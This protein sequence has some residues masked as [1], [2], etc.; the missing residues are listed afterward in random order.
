MKWIKLIHHLFLYS[1]YIIMI[2]SYVII[3]IEA[4][5]KL[6]NIYEVDSNIVSLV[7]IIIS[8]GSIYLS[9]KVTNW[10]IEKEVK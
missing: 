4:I 7:L 6:L 5:P 9:I 10:F 3:F 1:Y 8:Y 2:W